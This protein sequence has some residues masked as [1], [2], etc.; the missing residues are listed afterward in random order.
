MFERW[1]SSFTDVD[2][3]RENCDGG[4]LVNEGD[5]FV[6]VFCGDVDVEF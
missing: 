4:W 6:R 5:M 3:V 1:Y 2:V